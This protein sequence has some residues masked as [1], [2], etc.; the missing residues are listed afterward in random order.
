MRLLAIIA[1]LSGA[2]VSGVGIFGLYTTIWSWQI[3]AQS[4]SDMGLDP[5]RWRAHWLGTSVFLLALGIILIVI[6][7]GLWRRSSWAAKAWI[8]ASVFLVAAYAVLYLLKPLPYGFEQ[9]TLP[10]FLL[11]LAVA[12]VSCFIFWRNSTKS[13]SSS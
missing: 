3:L 10:E 9:G 7:I 5:Y 6:A 1:S 2:I 8:A 11:L 12:V 4:G 13:A